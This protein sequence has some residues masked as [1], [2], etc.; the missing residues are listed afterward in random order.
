MKRKVVPYVCFY[1]TYTCDALL[2]NMQHQI[3]N[4]LAT[5]E[6]GQQG[7]SHQLVGFQEAQQ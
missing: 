4:F 6:A 3:F 2:F 7:S 5:L 1:I